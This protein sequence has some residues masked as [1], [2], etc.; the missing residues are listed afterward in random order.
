MTAESSNVNES[1]EINIDTQI[2]KT[3]IHG[4]NEEL[5]RW[6]GPEDSDEEIEEMIPYKCDYEIKKGI[7]FSKNGIIKFVEEEMNKEDA[8]SEKW[9]EKL[10]FMNGNK[11]LLKQG[12]SEES[13]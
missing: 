12:G 9:E 1:S 7:K 10:N 8:I 2:K 11:L 5:L 4:D 3:N 13:D 6:D